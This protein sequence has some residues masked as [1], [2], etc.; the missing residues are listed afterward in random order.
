M[1]Q[2]ARETSKCLKLSV[3]WTGVDATEGEL[4]RK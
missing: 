1:G 4:S 2:N 3:A